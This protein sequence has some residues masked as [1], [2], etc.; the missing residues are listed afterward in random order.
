MINSQLI[1]VIKSGRHDAMTAKRRAT[2]RSLAVQREGHLY[3]CTSSATNKYTFSVSFRRHVL[4]SSEH[5]RVAAAR[6]AFK[7]FMIEGDL[8]GKVAGKLPWK[9]RLS[10]PHECDTRDSTHAP[11]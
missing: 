3:R 7:A 11:G 9:L 5:L 1:R 6:D 4:S 8:P 10:L 2:R